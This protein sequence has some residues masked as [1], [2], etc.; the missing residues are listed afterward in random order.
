MRRFLN[1]LA[2]ALC[3]LLPAFARAQQEPY[4]GTYTGSLQGDPVFLEL[5]TDGPGRW[6]GEMRDSQQS[7]AVRAE[8]DNGSI[9]GA[10]SEATYGITLHFAGKLSGNTLTLTFTLEGMEMEGF[11][12]AF[13]R[14][15]AVAQPAGSSIDE[16]A[17]DRRSRDP[18]LV[19]TWVN[20]QIYNSGYG[21]N[22]MGSTTITRI[23]LA[24][25]GKVYEGASSTTMG[26]SNYTGQSS[27]QGGGEVP[28]VRW[29]TQ[30]REIWFSV[31]QDGT[32]QQAR[33]GR[34]A[35]D[36]SNMMVTADNGEKLL[37]RKE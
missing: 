3:L 25:D 18:A 30:D 28:G 17:D 8:T 15:Q 2:L 19:G 22:F 11:D 12:V 26:G 4:A 10:A 29:Y 33:M 20:E 34:Y 27:G 9:H 21:D 35:V 24:R 14:E 32:T 5:K 31:A 36:G 7:F 13:T 6:T 37:F 23:T 1:R 16:M